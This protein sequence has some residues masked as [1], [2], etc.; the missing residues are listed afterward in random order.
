M[1]HRNRYIQWLLY[2]EKKPRRS[3]RHWPEELC[4]AREAFEAEDT[5]HERTLA[6]YKRCGYAYIEF[7]ILDG[8]DP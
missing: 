7:D 5:H 4:L 1:D 8:D 6:Q 2:W 3:M